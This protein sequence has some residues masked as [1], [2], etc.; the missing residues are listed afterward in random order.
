MQSASELPLLL[1]ISSEVNVKV[2]QSA[3]KPRAKPKREP[4]AKPAKP[5]KGKQVKPVE[6]PKSTV[7]VEE[8]DEG[9]SSTASQDIEP[10]ASLPSPPDDEVAVA[11]ALVSSNVLLI[12][13]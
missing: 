10:L 7:K 8:E 5:A 1:K 3:A 2:Q 4:K 13:Y 12:P 11:R 6:V 9:P